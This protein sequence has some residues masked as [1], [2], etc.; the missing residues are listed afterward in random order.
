M[1]KISNKYIDVLIRYSLLLIIALSGLSLIYFIFEPLTKYPVYFLFN[2][3][4]DILVAPG[5]V[6]IFEYYDI[7]LEIVGGCI[8]GSAYFLLLMLNLSTPNIKFSKRMKLLGFSFL[9]FLT[10]NIL[11]IFIIG[12]LFLNDFQWAEFIH[13]SLWYFGSIVLIIIIWFYQ[14][15]KFKISK[16]PFYSDVK[17]ILKSIK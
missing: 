10:F 6:I 14:V 7:S 3:I 5:N 13:K 12:V 8:A 15:K 11:R 17:L 16:I 2:S 4:Y 1:S 9:I